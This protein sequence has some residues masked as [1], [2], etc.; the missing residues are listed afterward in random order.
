MQIND[1]KPVTCLQNDSS[2]DTRTLLL[3]LISCFAASIGPKGQSLPHLVAEHHPQLL[4]L[5]CLARS[6]TFTCGNMPEMLSLSAPERGL[7]ACPSFPFAVTMRGSSFLTASV[8]AS[9][10]SDFS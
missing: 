6:M 8:K 4:Q 7:S 9:Q 1:Q 5:L 10:E 2:D 3:D